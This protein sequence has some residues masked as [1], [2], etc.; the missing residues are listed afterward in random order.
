[1]TSTNRR[2]G[3]GSARQGVDQ[4]RLSKMVDDLRRVDSPSARASRAP[5][6]RRGAHH[7]GPGRG[8]GPARVRDGGDRSR[9]R[10]TASSSRTITPDMP[11]PAVAVTVQQKLGA[12]R[13]ARRS[14]SRRPAPASSTACRSPTR[15]FAAGS[16]RTCWSSASRSVA[17]G[18]LDR[19]QHL[20]AVRRRRRRGAAGAV[21][22]TT[23]HPVDAHLRR[24]R[25]HAVPEHPRRRLARADDGQDR[26]GQAALR[27]D[28][29]Q[30][31]LHA[32]G[33]E[34]LGGG[35]RSALEHNGKTR[36][37]RRRG[38]RASGE[39]AHPRGRGRALRRCRSTS[40]I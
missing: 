35:A 13:A 15:S 11:M 20:R 3:Q 37:R 23:R 2:H 12:S 5:H 19:S 7:V 40:S 27:Q 10:S 31:G 38:G 34:H 28:A 1:M 16:S 14:T 17:P 21:E 33:E 8:G 9:P 18:R 32:R 30:A 26:R 29:G 36:G 4:R 6:P 25:G 39:P 22:R 24:R